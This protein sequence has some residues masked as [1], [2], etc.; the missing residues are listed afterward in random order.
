MSS[1]YNL[2]LEIVEASFES[3]ET[4]RLMV[5]KIVD[6]IKSKID[7]GS[8]K[9]VVKSKHPD[10]YIIKLEDLTVYLYDK[11][12]LDPRAVSAQTNGHRAGYIKNKKELVVYHCD[13]KKNGETLKITFPEDAVNHELV[14]YLDFKGIKASAGGNEP[15]LKTQD[16][17]KDR[18]GYLNSPIELNAHFFHLAIPEIEKYLDAK[19]TLPSFDQFRRDLQARID[20]KNYYNALTP[21]NQKKVLKRLYIYYK[22]I[23]DTQAGKT[24][25]TLDTKPEDLKGGEKNDK[26]YKKKNFI[27]KIKGLFKKA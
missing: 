11:Y 13:I 16:P 17:N 10:H 26:V 21:D 7:S 25:V 15:K 6:Q 20:F 22:G 23:L 3:D 12:S 8:G 9:L 19:N 14:H 5:K 24:S 18:K 1:F 4:K 27:D 2:L